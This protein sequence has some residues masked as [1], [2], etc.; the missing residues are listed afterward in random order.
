VSTFRL[1][2]DLKRPRIQEANAGIERQLTPKLVVS[3]SFIYTKGDRLPVSFDQNLPAPQFTRVYVLPS[4]STVSV[5]FS[6]GITKTASGQTVNI[7]A[8]R[9]NPTTG[10]INV[11]TSI[12]ETWYKAL[13]L[14]VKRRFSKGFQLNIAYTLAKAENLS[15]SG[16]A[17]GSG[18]GSES[19]F[20]GSSVQNQFALSS[21]R[22][23]S[24][25]DQRHGLV[26]GG[27]WNL[28]TTSSENAV[29][30]GMVNGWS[31]SGIFTAESGRPF[32]AEVSVPSLPFTFQG[33]QYNGFG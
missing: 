31:L 9:P 5:P 18:T 1:D 20:G 3:A 30:R 22:A 11:V 12:G 32:A 29:I 6:A 8:S 2:S 23:P 16:A 21:N 13:F 15:G 17:D 7:N 4:G 24:S 19:P 25:T 10:A 14:E 27:I 33:A 28:P 26:A